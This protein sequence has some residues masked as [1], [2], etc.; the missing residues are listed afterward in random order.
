MGVNFDVLKP[1]VLKFIKTHENEDIVKLILKGSP[2][3]DIEI[4]DIAQQIKGRV[5]AKYKFPELYK[6]DNIIYPPKLNLEQTSSSPTAAYKAQFVKPDE[7]VIDVTGGLGI[8]T[9][10][11]AKIAKKVYYCEIDNDTFDYAN[12]NFKT[13][14]QDL[15]TFCGN[16]LEYLK[17][18]ESIFDWVYLDPARR[19]QYAQKIIRL[20]DSTPNILEH[21]SWLKTKT[22]HILLKTSPLLDI[23]LCLKKIQ[24]IREVHIVA[25]KNE[26]KELLFVIDFAFTGVIPMLYAVNLQTSQEDFIARYDQKETEQIYDKPQAYLY[27]PH[28][29]LMKSG[30]YAAICHSFKI[31]ALAKHSHLFTSDT[32]EV[33]PG[34]RFRI[35]HV[36]SPQKKLLNKLLPGHQANI[37]CRNYP[38]KPEQIKAKYGIRDGGEVYLFF[39]TNIKNQKIILFC[40]KIRS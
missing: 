39:T 5:V 4:Q 38:L 23:N 24:H 34:R 21:L 2:F 26:V 18:Q 8:D 1:E 36:I 29:A 20:E 22:K 37:S 35:K 30:L 28:A 7:S 11:F 12:H 25:V 14:K 9:L 40:D 27:E 32:L 13:L 3:E 33:F 15:I 31:K 17:N 16:G 10:A 19:D 6:C